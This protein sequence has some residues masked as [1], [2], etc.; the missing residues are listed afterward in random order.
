M[1]K[2]NQSIAWLSFYGAML[3]ISI[4]LGSSK[5]P[6]QQGYATYYKDK[7]EGKETKCGGK[8]SQKKLTCASNFYECGTWLKVSHKC[9][10]VNV[11]VTDNGSFKKAVI[12]LSKSAWKLLEKDTTKGI[13]LVNIQKI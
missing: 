4:L 12:D 3:T 2:F 11:Q 5:E 13:I 1:K 7:Y 10:S 9:K 6:I 8:F